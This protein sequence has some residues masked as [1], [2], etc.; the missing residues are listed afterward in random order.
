[1]CGQ[2]LR[3]QHPRRCVCMRGQRLRSQPPRA[4]LNFATRRVRQTP[5]PPNTTVQVPRHDTASP[6]PPCEIKCPLF[7]KVP[8]RP[9]T[10]SVVA[11]APRFGSDPSVRGNIDFGGWGPASLAARWA[12]K[13]R[14]GVLVQQRRPGRSTATGHGLRRAWANT[15]VGGSQGGSGK[16]A[17]LVSHG[18]GRLGTGPRAS[19]RTEVCDANI[20]RWSGVG[21]AIHHC[22]EQT[23]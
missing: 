3:S 17:K 15:D 16:S 9:P 12:L 11:G 4:K 14:T 18:G 19:G 1:M 6:P 20:W 22:M 7:A 21:T 13:F 2:R 8:P 10:V 5:L 23:R